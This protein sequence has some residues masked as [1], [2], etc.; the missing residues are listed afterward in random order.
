MRTVVGLWAFFIVIIPYFVQYPLEVYNSSMTEAFDAYVHT[1]VEE[2]QLEGRF[3]PEILSELETKLQ[4]KFDVKPGDLVIRV[5]TKT[6]YRMNAFDE[7]ELITYK[8][9]MPYHKIV[10]LAGFFGISD[11]E[12]TGYRVI[13]GSAPSEKVLE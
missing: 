9:A 11:A 7:R 6:K 1:A 2:A 12:N 13:E 8:F 10:A 3:T 4:N 5:E